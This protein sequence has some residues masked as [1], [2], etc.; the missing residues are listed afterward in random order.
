M[1]KSNPDKQQRA[2]EKIAQI[3]A[4][5]ARRKRRRLLLAGAGAVGPPV[6]TGGVL[7]MFTMAEAEVMFPA[8][9]L[10]VAETDWP[11]PSLVTVRDT[12][13]EPAIASLHSH[14][15]VTSVLYQPAPLAGGRFSTVI[16]GAVRST[17]MGPAV[18][19]A[20]LPAMSVH[21]P[22]TN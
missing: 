14:V 10:Q 2:R 9:S 11:A 7:S 16:T 8:G 4:E 18:M 12:V 1:S 5:E 21:T 13:D 6:S 20:W 17:L 19:R 3:R 15:M 22:L